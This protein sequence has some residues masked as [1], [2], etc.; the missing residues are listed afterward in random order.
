M[1]GANELSRD[2][3][4]DIAGLF[5][6]LKKKLWLVAGVPALVGAGLFVMFAG[7]D[8]SYKS[9]ARIII[10]KRESIFTRRAEGDPGQSS[11]QFD[12]Q[13][14]GSQVAVLDSDDIALKVIERLKLVDNPEFND[15]KPSFM[16]NLL[17]AVG[18]SSAGDVTPQERVLNEFRTRLQVYA[19]EKSRV[20]AI[21]FWAHDRRLAQEIP[22]AIAEEYLAL[23][24]ASQLQTTED[25]TA[26]LGPEIEELRGKVREAEEKVAAFRANSDILIGNNN[27]LLSTQQLSEVSSELS[28]VRGDRSA[29]EGKIAA[30]RAAL[31]KGGSLDVIPEVMASG[32]VQR[33]RER[34]VSLQAQ[35]SELSTSL[36]PGH[37]RLK[38]LQSQ[39][40]D[41]SGQIRREARNI[42][43]SLENNV[44]LQ[45]KQEA[46]LLQEVN[47]LKAESGRV[48][49]AEVELRA[50]EREANAQR[51]LLETYLTRF[52]EAAGRTN[53][54]YLPID[55]R[56]ISRAVMPAS[57]F[58]P[59][60]IPFTLAGAVM[61][62]VLTVVGILAG[63]LL[64]G[65]ALKP[66]GTVTPSMVPERV[67]L[68]PVAPR[69]ATRLARTPA[70]APVRAPA[71]VS[72]LPEMTAPSLYSEPDRPLPPRRSSVANDPEVFAVDETV[73]AIA[74]LGRAR[75]AAISPGGDAGS[76]VTWQMA[77]L[78]ADA[79]N[80][81]VIVDL[82]GSAVTSRECLGTDNLAG[83]SELMARKAALPQVVY[84]D[85]ASPAHVIPAGL[86][87][88][89][90]PNA[91][92]E[93]A[94]IAASLA[95]Q[96]A[97]VV[98]DCGFAGAEGLEHVAD[99]ETIILV[100]AHGATRAET[101]ESEAALRAAGY[102][103]AVTVRLSG[104]VELRRSVA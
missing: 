96:Y 103:D 81:V 56:I 49:E 62:L 43:A 84:A 46:V 14:V 37:P 71:P 38:A 53:R 45:R 22:N 19:V 24:K 34:E 75:I 67:E 83:L 70:P 15:A 31:D 89:A 39:V 101:A 86:G 2:V 18:G 12:E 11:T 59:K 95:R 74:G 51:E 27:A 63:A 50:L 91:M 23:T 32:L 100:N 94:R 40:A 48:G 5:A 17:A 87:T 93:L 4:I 57:S 92:R 54:D 26:W 104:E 28:R 42:L 7:M 16:G 8:P 6:E 10:E 30:I 41:F 76:A 85:R 60:I 13:A 61:A 90:G 69:P 80:D 73:L 36:L 79:G 1:S 47:R 82:T 65:K 9:S 21:E 29:A 44:D 35:I 52:R 99:A 55:A 77:R 97:F 78:L 58:F 66:V 88:D 33:L 20:I 25:A 68:E 98:F 64:S 102:G 3:D 72:F